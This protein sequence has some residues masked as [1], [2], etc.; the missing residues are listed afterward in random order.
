MTKYELTINGV[1]VPT[2][3]ITIN[4]E[5]ENLRDPEDVG[6]VQIN[7]EDCHIAT[8]DVGDL[9]ASLMVEQVNS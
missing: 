3:E 7:A 1:E 5:P 6:K 9:L 8:D 2:R 4:I